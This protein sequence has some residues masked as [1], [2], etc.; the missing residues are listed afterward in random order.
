M[1]RSVSPPSAQC[2]R[3]WAWSPR[4]R[5]HPGARQCRSRCLSSRKMWA[6]T[7]RV[8]RPSRIGTPRASSMTVWRIASHASRRAV[9]FAIGMPV[10]PASRYAPGSSEP[11]C[12]AASGVWT[13]S[14]ARCASPSSARSRGQRVD[15]HVG[16]ADRERLPLPVLVRADLVRRRGRA[17]RRPR[18]PSASGMRPR[19]RSSPRFS[20]QRNVELAPAVALDRLVGRDGA[21]VA[22]RAARSDV[23]VQPGRLVG[24]RRVGRRASRPGRPLRAAR[25]RAGLRAR[26]C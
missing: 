18:A 7:V 1:S 5:V 16:A 2:T 24:P 8:R 13:I 4:V 25:P 17:R 9:S 11:S 23:A 10:S 6:G 26:R 3:W 22:C 19:K 15:E 21:L 12:S 14:V 20:S